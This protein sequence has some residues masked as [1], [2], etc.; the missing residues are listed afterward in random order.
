MVEIDE[1]DEIGKI[2]PVLQLLMSDLDNTG[3]AHAINRAFSG[4]HAT[5]LNKEELKSQLDMLR[6]AIA[7]A[8]QNADGT[9][10]LGILA[11]RRVNERL[12]AAKSVLNT[13]HTKL[14]GR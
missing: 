10:P 2:V 7:G 14:Y 4:L 1:T 9:T 11:A 12:L 3:K 6:I 8:L 13:I 5:V